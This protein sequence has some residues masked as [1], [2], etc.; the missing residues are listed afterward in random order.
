MVIGTVGTYSI[1]G[2]QLLGGDVGV[3]TTDNLVATDIEDTHSSVMGSSIILAQVGT[4]CL[5]GVILVNVACT[6]ALSLLL[7]VDAHALVDTEL[8]SDMLQRE[9]DNASA[10]VDVDNKSASGELAA[11]SEEASGVMRVVNP[12]PMGADIEDSNAP[13][14]SDLER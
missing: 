3:A 10:S 12:P 13:V 8:L 1:S 2:Q 9:F 14:A 11:A 5:S 4:D 6:Q 7:E